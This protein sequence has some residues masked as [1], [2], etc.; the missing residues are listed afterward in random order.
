MLAK[1][2]RYAEELKGRQA[3]ADRYSELLADALATPIIRGDRSS[4]WAQYTVRVED[5]DQVQE[6]LKAA[7]VPTAVHYPM[8]LH[9]Q[10]CFAYLG[11]AEGLFPVSEEVAVEVMSLPMNPFLL[12]EEIVYVAEK[13][14]AAL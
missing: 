2:P 1:L 10:E 3:V 8:P 12:D 9:R 5:R 11:L 14:I 4:V 13:L 7:G 6:S